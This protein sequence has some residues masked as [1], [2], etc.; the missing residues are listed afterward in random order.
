MSLFGSE[1]N[2]GAFSA[3]VPSVM[4]MLATLVLLAVIVTRHSGAEQAMWTVLVMASS[5][6][7]IMAAKICLTDSVLILFIT[8]AQFCLFAIWRGNRSWGVAILMAVMFGLGGLTKGPF[9]LGIVA[10]TVAALGIFRALDWM[11]ERRRMRARGF[12]VVGTTIP[13][14][15][16]EPLATFH[17]DMPGN[18]QISKLPSDI[19]PFVSIRARTIAQIT[20][21]V[22]II[23][24][25]VLPWI[26]LVHHRAPEFLP[27]IFK[28]AREH[29]ISGK[30]GHSFPPGY[31]LLLI[32]PMFMPW[33][34]LL[35]LAIGLGI[36]NRK[37][38]EVRFALA[39]VLGPWVMVEL[40]GT[41][42][43]HYFLAA[44]PAL[45]FLV[46]FTIRRCL[47]TNA[48]DLRSKP[49]IVAAFFWALVAASIGWLP[50]LATMYFRPLP[51][52]AMI[53]LTL[54]S[55]AYAIVVLTL[56]LR[57]RFALV[58]W[59]M[60][61]GMLVAAGVMFT[62]YFPRADFLRISIRVADVLKR[63]SATHPG[64]VKMIDY[65]EPSL[66]FYQGGTIREESDS[67]RFPRESAERVA[68]MGGHDARG[69]AKR[70]RKG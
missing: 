22:L 10:C 21:G 20:V 24:A 11:I 39:A 60:G 30:E 61:I 52:N 40:I 57:R 4:A 70:A 9:I 5:A 56:I 29:T 51:W 35:P 65:K 42:L 62:A 31:H 34:L 14:P 47:H 48:D 18:S 3:R 44:Y 25:I 17:S 37:V 33:S 66:G 28:E 64:D 55:T 7:T 46:A 27:R 68:E 23:A 8:V 59:S 19:Y 13:Y 41:K 6:M 2:A 49:F 63:E 58:F 36:V 50:W 32:W 15:S 12:E 45:A 1:G 53:L 38:P 69:V 43:P 26:L 54:I 16:I 67:K